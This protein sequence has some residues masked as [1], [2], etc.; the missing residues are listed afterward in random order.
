[1]QTTDSSSSGP[2]TRGQEVSSYTPPTS[3]QRTSATWPGVVIASSQLEQDMS[4]SGEYNSASTNLPRGLAGEDLRENHLQVPRHKLCW[5]V[6][7]SL[8]FSRT[9]PLLALPPSRT[10]KPL[11]A[12]TGARSAR[13]AARRTRRRSKLRNS[14]ALAYI[15]SQ[16]N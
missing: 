11:C 12:P 4:R 6:T 13:S 5:A 7:V 10:T 1:M 9:L 15:Q 14:S 16:R 3:A 8:V 2:S